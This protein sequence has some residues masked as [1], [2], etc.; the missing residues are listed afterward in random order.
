MSQ[1]YLN[2]DDSRSY[3]VMVAVR[4]VTDLPLIALACR[5]A[6]VR[7]GKIC[8][9][10]VASSDVQPAWLKLPESC[11]DIPFDIVIRSDTDISNA[12]L[13]EVQQR[14]TDTLILGWGGHLGQ[15]LHVLGRTLDPVIQRAACDI[16]VMRGECTED[17]RRVLIPAAGGPNAPEAFG[18]ARALIPEAELTTL[19]VALEK[20]GPAEVLVGEAR[21][22]TM[23]HGLSHLDREHV[24]TRVIQASGPIEGILDEAARGYDILIIGAGNENIVGRFLFGDIPQS[25]AVASPIPVMIVR[26]RLTNLN[27]VVRRVWTFIFGLVPTLTIQEQAEV[28]KSIRRGSRPSTD[29]SVMITLA[30]AIATL[31]LLLNS[32]AVIIG[33][34]LVAPLMS[35]ILGMG[36]ALVIGDLRFFWTA[37][38]TTF[39]GILLA[40]IT[41][42]VV[43]SLVP[44]IS[45]T[46]EILGRASPFVLDLGVAL[47]SG[48]A[49]AYALSRKDV[50]AAL[51]GVAI[52]AALAPPLATVGIGLVL[53]EY[54]ISGGALLL[55]TTNMISIIAASGLVFFLLGFRPAPGDAGRTLVLRRG[56]QSVFILLIIVTFFLVVLTR[57]SLADVRLRQEIQTVLQSEVDHIPG[58]ELVNWKITE[59]EPDGTLHIDVT[60]RALSAL[61]Y[62]E[63]RAVQENVAAEL[64]R[65]VALSLAV[66]PA[67]RLQAYIPPTPTMTPTMTPTGLPTATPTPTNTST[68]TAT[69]TATPMPSPTA[70]A[71][72]TPTPTITP[73]PSA[74][75]TATPWVMFV[76]NVERTGLRVHY[77]PNGTVM[78]RIAEGTAVIVLDGPVTVG[79]TMWYR[80]IST[81]DRL[82]GW[83]AAEYLAPTVP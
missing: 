61:A 13:S 5:L 63:A 36:M 14:E 54:W 76:V 41:S 59:T 10:T 35:P 49:A 20:L 2:D 26:R 74:T 78:G 67:T 65:P 58:G 11:E 3:M 32:P 9:L 40:I 43:G 83:V 29:F 24:N 47:V 60:I 8:V 34:M 33:A 1:R 44:G 48:A 62:A 6:R 50:S 75:P 46:N 4:D 68:A 38:G 82:E 12:I 42:F 21:L 39:R 66:V 15:D 70:T 51:A 37:L 28:S 57:Q 30:A 25:V 79:E 73:T 71:T 19:Y 69:P 31:G 22:E 17:V 27:S 56:F 81:I 80:V 18:I 7:K 52:A 45:A 16:I 72:P 77:S 53:R 55:F 64:K 23:L